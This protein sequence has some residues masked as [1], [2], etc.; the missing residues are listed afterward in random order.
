VNDIF[1]TFGL[2]DWKPVAAA[3]L[4]PP[5][6][7]LLMLLLAWWWQRRRPATA[8]VLLMTAVIALWFSHCQV[9]GELLERQ[10]SQAPTLS[11]Q[12]LADLRRSAADG[13]TAI[14]VLSA[15]VRPLASEYGESQPGRLS[16][17]RLEYALWLS[18]QVSVPLLVAGGPGWAHRDGPAEAPI[19]AR[20]A[21]RDH[22]RAVRWIEAES[23]DTRSMARFSLHM[24]RQSGVNQVILVTHGW[25]MQRAARAFTEED[26]HAPAPVR[27]VQAPMGMAVDRLLPPLQRWTPTAEGALRVRQALREWVG[28][29][30]GA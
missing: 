10:L 18:R 13:R 26:A 23:H 8:T 28:L 22:G 14:V 25:H 27:L 19:L 4:L 6:P 12:R 24:L 29:A 11:T 30:A 20:I 16:M 9:T 3:F 7:L 1:A 15:G 17:E 2:L 21:S 5:V